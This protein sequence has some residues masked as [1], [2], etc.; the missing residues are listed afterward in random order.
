MSL[1]DVKKGDNVILCGFT[2]IKLGVFEVTKASEKSISITKKDGSILTF[3]RK[4]GKQTN[5]EE[6]KE[7]YANSV[8]EDDGSYTPPRRK[9]KVTKKATKK[10][11]KKK[12]AKKAEPVEDEEP[13]DEEELEDEEF[14]DLDDEE[15][16]DLDDE[17]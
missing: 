6:G 3:S 9:K 7:R 13:E 8:M 15:F 4:T 17:E 12:S 14:E 11:E 10:A 16:E 1:K 5:V 2:G